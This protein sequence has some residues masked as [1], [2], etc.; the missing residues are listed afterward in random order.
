VPAKIASEPAVRRQVLSEATAPGRD[1]VRFGLAIGVAAAF[2]SVQLFIIPRRVDMATY[3][4]YRLFLVYTAY[5]GLLHFGLADGSFLRWAGLRADAIRREWRIVGRWLLTI[6]AIVL[7]IAL[8]VALLIAEPLTRLYVIALATTALC[9]NMATLSAFALQAA[10]DFRSAG[11]VALI[12]P[13][14][15]VLLVL[16]VPTASLLALL[17]MYVASC[18]VSALYG[19]IRVARIAPPSPAETHL[20]A[21]ALAT[22]LER[23]VPVLMA[24]V[25]AGVS[26]S[27]D[28]ILVSAGTPITS[29]ALYGFAS[30][31]SVAATTATHALSRVALSH[32]ARRSSDERAPFLFGFL[33]VIAS[34]YGV[35]LLAEPLFEHLVKT[36][37][38][39]YTSA[40]P[41]V[42]ALTLGVPFWAAAHVVL[43]GTLQS[44]GFVRRQLAVEL[45]GVALV[46]ALCAAA[47]SRPIPLWSV[48]VAA[49]I[50][51]AMTFAIGAIVVR[52]SVSAAR[53]QSGLR[54]AG[55]VAV[56]GVA[57]LVALNSTDS[58][59]V[60]SAAYV[61]MTL[62]PT[63]FVL[64][65]ARR[66]PW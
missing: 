52:R 42:R 16:L 18:A 6:Q 4:H 31:V 3:G 54:F 45:C 15:F 34:A 14:L 27:V 60:Q 20:D 62:V 17:G 65:R 44:Y 39:A 41:M 1:V 11:R 66:Q 38:P 8:L 51:A 43:V 24:N 33:D 35:L 28:R 63:V 19:A 12:V 49:T 56:Q 59:I 23:G 46:I 48:A 57:L 32:A 40:L 22:L 21:P 55:V 29:F 7:S 58:W 13:C 2:S 50:A 47:L 10:G 37:L 25:A 53:G 36:F 9:T 30:T 5:L 61:A 26:Q 64:S